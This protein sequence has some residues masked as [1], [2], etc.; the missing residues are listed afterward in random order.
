VNPVSSSSTSV[1][2]AT[3]TPPVLTPSANSTQGSV[4]ASWVAPTQDIDGSNLTDLSGFKLYY[5]TASGQYAQSVAVSGPSD[6]SQIISG[7]IVGQTYFFVVTAVNSA[8]EESAY[9]PEV[10]A[11]IT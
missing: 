9:S 4:T 1:P 6:L 5:G 7:L 11:T 3:L 8:G 10:S 2:T